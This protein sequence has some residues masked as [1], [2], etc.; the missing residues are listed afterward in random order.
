MLFNGKIAPLVPYGIRG[1]I[2]YQGEANAPLARQYRTLFPAMIKGWRDEWRQGDF[3]FYFVQL[4]N[5]D[6]RLAI[7]VEA[8]GP[9]F[10]RHN[11]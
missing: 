9:N 10:A 5:S 4:A 7:A 11:Y 2:W 6:R 8:H 1:V 3:P